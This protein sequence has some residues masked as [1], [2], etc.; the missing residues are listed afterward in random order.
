MNEPIIKLIFAILAVLIVIVGGYFPYLKNIFLKKT[1]P[2]AYAWLIWSITQGTALAALFYGN[3]G[4]GTIALLVGVIFTSLIFLFSLIYGTKN[5]TKGDTIIL[6]ATLLAIVVW[7]QLH[8]PLLSV[9]MVS[10]IDFLGYIP[11]FRKTFAEPWTETPISWLVFSVANILTILA[12]TEYNF[13]TLAYLI[14]MTAANIILLAICLL[15][16]RVIA[17]PNYNK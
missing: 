5:I 8:A 7:W 10:I 11:T 12:L 13:M 17:R 1:K 14:T 6:I 16:R 9:L 3:G 2:H 15:R 4:W